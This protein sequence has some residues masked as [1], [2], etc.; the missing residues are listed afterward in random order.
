MSLQFLG[1]SQFSV[2]K[3]FPFILHSFR[4]SFLAPSEQIGWCSLLFRGLFSPQAC[5]QV[6]KVQDN[7]MSGHVTHQASVSGRWTGTRQ[8]GQGPCLQLQKAEPGRGWRPW[9]ISCVHVAFSLVPLPLGPMWSP[10]FPWS[11]HGV[12]LRSKPSAWASLQAVCFPLRRQ[13]SD[14][15]GRRSGSF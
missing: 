10:A 2:R 15:T 11:L 12:S 14:S 9:Y 1:I 13:S 3:V 8:E 6:G 5:V 4:F 7:C